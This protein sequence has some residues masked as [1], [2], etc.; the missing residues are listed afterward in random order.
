MCQSQQGNVIHLMSPTHWEKSIAVLQAAA[1]A[2][3]HDTPL[4]MALL[5][6]S[7]EH[8][9]PAALQAAS[10]LHA[11]GRPCLAAKC[12]PAVVTLLQVPVCCR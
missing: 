9:A 12:L 11:M 6:P 8:P 2:R 1:G 7:S 5:R 10:S 3:Q 4:C